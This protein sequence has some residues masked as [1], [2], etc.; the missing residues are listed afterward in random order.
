[1]L[2]ETSLLEN[3]ALRLSAP[4][5]LHD[6]GAIEPDICLNSDDAG[7]LIWTQQGRGADRICARRFAAQGFGPIIEWSSRAGLEYQP[8]LALLPDGTLLG[9][10]VARRQGEYQLIQR[11]LRGEVLGPDQVVY[12]SAE[13]LFRPR[14]L[15]SDRRVWLV[16][17]AVQ[18]AATRLAVMQHDGTAWSAAQF[19]ETSSDWCSRAALARRS[20][21]SIWCAYDAY[22]DGYY[23]VYLQRLDEPGKALRVT[24]EAYQSVQPA[25]AAGSDSTLW[26]AY[27]SNANKARRDPWWLTK[28]NTV[29]G[30][31]GMAFFDLPA[32][33]ERDIYQDDSFQGWEF[34][35]LHVEA[36][37]HVWLFGQSAHT[38]YMASCGAHGW[39]ALHNIAEKHWGSWKPRMRTAGNGPVYL[40][41]MGLQGAQLQRLELLQAGAAPPQLHAHA[42]FPVQV[43]APDHGLRP[44]VQTQ[45]GETLRYYF[46]DLHAHSIYGDATN[47]VDE[48][49]HRYRD[50][51]GYDF[52]CLT[53]HDYLDG[54][55]LGVAELNMLWDVARRFSQPGRFIA[56]YGYEW[57]SPAIAAHAAPGSKVGEGHRHVIYPDDMGELVSYGH[58]ETNT[59]AK[60]LAHLKGRRVLVVPHHTSWAGTDWDAHDPSIQRVVEICSTHGRFEYPGNLPIGYRRDHI[61]Q[62]KFVAQALARG[63]RLGF[64]G[65]SDSHGLRWHATEP[66]GRE[67]FVPPGTRVGWKEDAYR[68]GMT[69]LL[70]PVLTR[71]ALYEALVQRRCYATTG[72]RIVLD[73]RING[74]LMGSE[75]STKQVPQIQVR[76]TGT[77]P[78][79][80]VEIIRSGHVFGGV[81]LQPGESIRTLSFE[82]QDEIII[83]G[84]EHY[85][86]LRVL[87]NDGNMAW[88]SPIWVN[89]VGP[90]HKG[91]LHS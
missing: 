3:A 85:Y 8:A 27:A 62:H 54:I 5:P 50:A 7:L 73:F 66:E 88:S 61:H 70:A 84:E 82:L 75:I 79:H 52:A 42:P 1:M 24:P 28:W 68:T 81:H 38:L 32:Q 18:G 41:A 46:G 2:F 78:L 87:Q 11:E 60:L 45:Q 72:E 29:R 58:P 6:Q 35:A 13:G 80:A 90:F 20:D 4:Q 36:S 71:E 34:P 12:R 47:D 77:A 43:S 19:L 21:G 23:A 89:F 48:I 25:L 33:P 53:E 15:V 76:V 64:V 49:Y 83:P 44:T 40:V 57:T 17:E 30:F 31:D 56:M 65:G 37:G 91:E 51:Y 59:G 39:S 14:L 69:A 9:L 22:H 26:I 63:Y 67:S 86:Y 16:F 74:Q 10:H 55:Q